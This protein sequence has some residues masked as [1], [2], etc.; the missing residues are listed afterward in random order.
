MPV[1]FPNNPALNDTYTVDSR[2]WIW[3]GIAWKLTTSAVGPTGP[4]GPAG[5]EGADGAQG[6]AG[7]P[8][9]FIVSA[10]PPSTPEEGDAWFNSTNS[11]LYMYYDSYWV[12]ASAP[13]AGPTGPSG[14]AGPTGPIG[15]QGVFLVSD[16]MPM[17]A[18]SGDAWFDS[19]TSRTYV[20]MNNAWVE[21]IGAAGPAGAD[22][23]D[24]ADGGFD[25]AQAV[26][27]KSANY[28]IQS[29]DAGKLIMN[30]AAIT[31]TVQ[32]LSVGQQVDFF[33]NSSSQITFTPG[34]G[35]TIVSKDSKLKTAAAYSAASVKCIAS[36]T[37]ALVGDLG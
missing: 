32:G 6:P 8:G 25:T 18:V 23:L 11:R 4:T 30:S 12:E 22:G 14:I 35:I 29:T 1:D 5:Y 34:S 31:I 7:E 13:I 3:N 33:Q 16:T 28:T 2:T 36:N 15:P 19:S 9:K 10:S 21:V 24:G 20:Y 37:Y 27:N 26:E 17:T